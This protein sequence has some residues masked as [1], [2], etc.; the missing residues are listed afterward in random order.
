MAK[1]LAQKASNQRA[2]QRD[3]VHYRARA[4]DTKGAPA[5]LLIVNIT[6]MGMMARGEMTGDVGDRVWITLP[7]VGSVAAEIRWALGGRIG[8]ELTPSIALSDYDAVLKAMV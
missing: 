1:A 6:V 5:A 7:V 4:T 2:L 3:E 8:F